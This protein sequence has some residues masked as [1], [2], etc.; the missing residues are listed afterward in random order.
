MTLLKANLELILYS[1]LK[2]P[3]AYIENGVESN[4]VFTPNFL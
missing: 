3:S 2:Y 1:M 4:T